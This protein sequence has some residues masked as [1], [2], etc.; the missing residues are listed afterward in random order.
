[1][2]TAASTGPFVP[3]AG[4]AVR[5]ISRAAGAPSPAGRSVPVCIR[6]RE[7]VSASHTSSASRVVTGS[8]PCRRSRSASSAVSRR[9]AGMSAGSL[10]TVS[11]RVRIRASG[12]APT[13]SVTA[14]CASRD[15]VQKPG[16]ADCANGSA[17]R[18]QL[19]TAASA[20]AAGS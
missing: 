1:M 17:A 14:R 15:Q 6:S 8:S 10:A 2:T 16:A 4:R 3:A 19:L 11:A 12:S 9:Q 13:A 18:T 7:E 5:R 20:R